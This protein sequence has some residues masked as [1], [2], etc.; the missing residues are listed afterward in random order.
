M[1]NGGQVAA[2]LGLGSGGVP[3]ACLCV[4]ESFRDCLSG[5]NPLCLNPWFIRDTQKVKFWVPNAER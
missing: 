1:F 3:P 2:A 4:R 5:D